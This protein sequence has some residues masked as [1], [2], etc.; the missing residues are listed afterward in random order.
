MQR[1]ELGEFL[2][3]EHVIT[4]SQLARAREMQLV[5]GAHLDSIL[6]SLGVIEEPVLLEALGRFCNTRTVTASELALASPDTIQMVP[7][8]LAQRYQVVPF[9]VE[10]K[11]LFIACTDTAD[12]LV[13]DE[14]AFLTGCQVRSCVGLQIRVLEALQRC[15][16]IQQPTFFV[17]LS[18]Q[19]AHPRARSAAVDEGS[20]APPVAESTSAGTATTDADTQP[21]PQPAP[22]PKRAV[23]PKAADVM[24]LSDE[25]LQL[26]PSLAV[27]REAA[28]QEPSAEP[29][30]AGNSEPGTAATPMAPVPD[31]IIEPTAPPAAT[32]RLY[33]AELHPDERLAAASEMLLDVELRDEIADVI[34]AYCAPYLRRRMLLIVRKDRTLGWRGDGEG[35]DLASVRA[36]EIPTGD[37]S[38]FYAL[39]QGQSFWLGSLPPMPRNS[40]LVFALGGDPPPDC[41]IL[42]VILRGKTVCF[43][44]GDN[45]DRGVGSA[46]MAVLRR[47]TAKA[48]LAFEVYIMKNKIRQL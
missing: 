30:P 15:Y 22:H 42:P 6:L 19:L 36:I 7:P 48:G 20:P 28:Q 11:T 31:T 5:H 43:L 34:L 8:R 32:E 24:E 3:K 25:D 18:R 4:A 45:L 14:V 37:P 23:R 46:P 38:V 9:R 35:I 39:L 47:L 16:G 26:F 10:G 12:L 1:P 29:P 13:E 17:A 2:F 40:E 33:D 41:L 21:V 44:Y 27:E